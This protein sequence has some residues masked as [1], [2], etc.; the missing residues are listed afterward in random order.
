MAVCYQPLIDR[1]EVVPD[2]LL[3]LLSNPSPVW[4]SCVFGSRVINFRSSLC[5]LTSSAAGLLFLKRS[6]KR[7][8][9]I[10]RKKSI[11]LRKRHE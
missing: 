9:C 3:F 10:L 2:E 5:G 8:F 4:L 7:C 6:F 11:K 1:S